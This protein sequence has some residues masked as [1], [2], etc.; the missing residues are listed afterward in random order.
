MLLSIFSGVENGTSFASNTV[1]PAARVMHNFVTPIMSV[2]VVIAGVVCTALLVYAGL[3]YMTASGQPIKL[4]EAKKIIKN[5]LVGLVIVIGAAALTALLAHAYS[6]SAPAATSQIMHLNAV[7]SQ[8]TGN[9]LSAVLTKMVTGFL[10]TIIDTVARPFLVALSYFTNGT[11]AMA[12]NPNVF[13]LWLC[14]LAIANVLVVFVF[15]LSGFH[16]MSFSALGLPE[17][18]LKHLAPRAIM[19]FVG[20]NSSIFLIDGIISLSNVMINALRAVYPTT[21]VWNALAAA[22]T[23][24]AGV[25]LA[26]LLIMIVVVILAAI[27]LVYYVGRLVTLYVGAVL[28]PLLILLWLVPSFRYFAE[29]AMKLY[30]STIFVLFIHVVILQLAAS[31]FSGIALAGAA[32]TADPIMALIV[33]LATIVAL[34]KTQGLMMQLSYASIGPRTARM[35]GGQLVNSVSYLSGQMRGSAG[36]ANPRPRPVATHSTSLHGASSFAHQAPRQQITAS[37]LRIRSSNSS[38]KKPPAIETKGASV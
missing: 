30:L 1:T 33:G 19:V 32:H 17:I 29:N 13:Q 10:Q 15:A 25:S 12:A 23:Q 27:L 18:S 24:S 5:A 22:T 20:M 14:I 38:A 26:A 21:T 16:I 11:P 7:Q 36:Y 35:L 9:S 34:L 4:L 8:P 6:A 37:M 2:A 31:I 3:Q 28:S